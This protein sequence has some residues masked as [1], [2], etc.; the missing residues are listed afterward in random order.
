M[1][2]LMKVA[3]LGALS[4]SPILALADGPSSPPPPPPPNLPEGGGYAFVDSNG[5]LWYCNSQGGNCIS[6]GSSADPLEP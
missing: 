1:K 6:L 4:I 3:L 2:L 5:D